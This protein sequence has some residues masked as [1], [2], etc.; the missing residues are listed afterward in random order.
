VSP[1]D[2]QRPLKANILETFSALRRRLLPLRVVQ[3]L[4]DTINPDKPPKNYKEAMSLP[5]KQEWEEA[6]QKEYLGFKE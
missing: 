6:N 1:I 2:T 4:P 5:E 3:G